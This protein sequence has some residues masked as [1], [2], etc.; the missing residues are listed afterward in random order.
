LEP[1]DDHAFAG[2]DSAENDPIVANGFAESHGSNAHLVAGI[3][4]RKLARTLDVE[5]RLLRNEERSLLNSN[6]GSDFAVLAWTQDVV[7]IRKQPG[8]PDGASL[9]VDL[10]VCKVDSAFVRAP[11]WLRRAA[12]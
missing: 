11:R 2:L 10:T 5:N 3:D 1:F 8:Q 6:C 7:G 4:N 9:D 12:P